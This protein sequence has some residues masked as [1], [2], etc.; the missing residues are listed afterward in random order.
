M[1]EATVV[2]KVELR[3]TGEWAFDA[4]ATRLVTG[5]VGDSVRLRRRR[6][7]PAV[8]TS[9]VP[10]SSTS[11]RR[12]ELSGTARAAAVGDRAVLAVSASRGLRVL[13]APEGA[14]AVAADLRRGLV[15]SASRPS[16]ARCRV[17]S[18]GSPWET[19]RP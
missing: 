7:R 6:A 19:R 8:A 5:A 11:A 14:F 3:P 4:V 13:R 12:S 18:P 17:W 15:G 1:V 16:R 2:G 10:T 9:I